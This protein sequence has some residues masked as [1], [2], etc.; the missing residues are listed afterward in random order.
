MPLPLEMWT[1]YP[2]LLL[3]SSPFLTTTFDFSGAGSF[4]F[5][6]ARRLGIYIC[7][8]TMTNSTTLILTNEISITLH[9]VEKSEAIKYTIE[10]CLVRRM[11]QISDH[12]AKYRGPR[13][14]PKN[15]RSFHAERKQTS[16]TEARIIG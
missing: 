7:L 16:R 1:F 5:F 10:N 3:P 11:F 13:K 14:Y 9:W 15:G 12:S 4:D 8:P 6:F 2:P